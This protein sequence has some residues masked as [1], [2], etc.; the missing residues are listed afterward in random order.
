[1]VLAYKFFGKYILCL[2]VVNNILIT[3]KVQVVGVT[4]AACPFPCMNDLK[5]PVV[6]LDECSQMTEP[7]SLLPIAR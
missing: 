3:I 6:V 5:F 4:C 1:M 2:I 7:A